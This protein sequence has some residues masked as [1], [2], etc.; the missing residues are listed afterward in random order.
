MNENQVKKFK[1]FIFQGQQGKK[2]GSLVI[3]NRSR[4]SNISCI[5]DQSIIMHKKMSSNLSDI[6]AQ[7]QTRFQKGKK[8]VGLLNSFIDRNNL[9]DMD[10]S[11]SAPQDHSPFVETFDNNL[12]H[13]IDVVNIVPQEQE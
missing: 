5:T 6:S 12:F 4:N 3:S 9:N 7:N 8:R 13:D 11:I 1:Q 10:K 2:N